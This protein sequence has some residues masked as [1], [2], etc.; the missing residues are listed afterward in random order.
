MPAGRAKARVGKGQEGLPASISRSSRPPQS[1]T[2]DALPI[3]TRRSGALPL[4]RRSGALPLSRRCG[5]P[6]PGQLVRPALTPWA[7]V[8]GGPAWH[9]SLNERLWSGCPPNPWSSGG[10][11]RFGRLLFEVARDHLDPQGRRLEWSEGFTGAFGPDARTPREYGRKFGWAQGNDPGQAM[12][13]VAVG[14]I[15]ERD[16]RPAAAMTIPSRPSAKPWGWSTARPRLCCRHPADESFT[17]HVPTAPTSSR[18]STPRSATTRWFRAQQ[19]C[20]C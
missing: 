11:G 16:R 3:H 1:L 18:L 19:G 5:A 12:V 2:A 20:Q 4:S 8:A 9:H 10:C 13:Y 14:D 17:G 6:R 15:P 7:L